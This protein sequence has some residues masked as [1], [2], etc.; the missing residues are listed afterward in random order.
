MRVISSDS[1]FLTYQKIF[2]QLMASD[3]TVVVWQISPDTGIRRI[4]NSKINA[5][6][7]ESGKIFLQ[8]LDEQMTATL[9]VYCYAEEGALFLKLRFWT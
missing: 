3:S 4:S 7:F 8:L 2:K 1:G 9:P 5:L 6:H